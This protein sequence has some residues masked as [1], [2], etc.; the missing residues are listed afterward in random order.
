LSTNEFD[1]SLVEASIADLRVSSL[2]LDVGC[3]PAQISALV[4]THGHFPVGIDLSI[5]M[6]LAAKRG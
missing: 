5:E 1:R 6:L 3:G 4:S 2:I